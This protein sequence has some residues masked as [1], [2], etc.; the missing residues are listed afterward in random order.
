MI[1]DS[2][3]GFLSKILSLTLQRLPL[4]FDLLLLLLVSLLS[5]PKH[6]THSGWGPAGLGHVVPG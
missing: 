2:V 3:F 5:L 6:R 4:L 1:L